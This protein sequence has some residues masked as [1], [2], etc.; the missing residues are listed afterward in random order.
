MKKFINQVIRKEKQ[1]IPSILSRDLLNGCMWKSI[2]TSNSLHLC[3]KTAHP[4]WKHHLYNKRKC[5]NVCV[6][7]AVITYQTIITVAWNL[8]RSFTIIKGW[9]YHKW[10]KLAHGQ[11]TCLVAVSQILL[12]WLPLLLCSLEGTSLDWRNNQEVT[13]HKN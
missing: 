6:S 11:L 3:P 5:V 8:Y 4:K 9:R 13:D 1:H 2:Y 12:P 7:V 10:S